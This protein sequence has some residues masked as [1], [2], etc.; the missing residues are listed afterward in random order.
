MQV[1]MFTYLF[2]VY[3]YK[4]VEFSEETYLPP[5]LRQKYMISRL[6]GEGACGEVRLVF[7]KVSTS[8][9]ILAVSEMYKL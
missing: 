3:T 6:L 1:Y 8:I 5:K 9:S 2:A 4:A 7:E